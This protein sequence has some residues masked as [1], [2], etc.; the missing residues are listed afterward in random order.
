M[1]ELSSINKLKI[2][3]YM[4]SHTS[5]YQNKSLDK[6]LYFFIFS[7]IHYCVNIYLKSTL[8]KVN[9]KG[10]MFYYNQISR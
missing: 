6:I 2:K 5:T 3:R 8:D 10:H 1:V 9:K 7:I 4:N